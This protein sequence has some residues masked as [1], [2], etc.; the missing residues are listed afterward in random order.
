MSSTMPAGKSSVSFMG[1]NEDEH[2]PNTSAAL[3]DALLIEGGSVDPNH[4]QPAYD[5]RQSNK[6]MGSLSLA[7]EIDHNSNHRRRREPPHLSNGLHSPEGNETLEESGSISE[8]A[9]NRLQHLAEAQ[10][11]PLTPNLTASTD[12]SSPNSNTS[13]AVSPAGRLRQELEEVRQRQES[14]RILVEGSPRTPQRADFPPSL[15]MSIVAP[16]TE[17]EVEHCVVLLHQSTGNE[18]S[19]GDL[20]KSLRRS[21]PESAFVLIRG[22]QAVR[23]G[24]SGYHWADTAWEARFIQTSTVILD[25]I[26]KDVLM[27]KCHFQPQNI[28]L[29]GYREG[30]MAALAA[31]A[32]WQGFELGG[33]ISIGGP[34]PDYVQLEPGVRAK[35][36]A[37]IIGGALGEMNAAA[38]QL[39]QKSFIYTHTDIRKGEHDLIPETKEQLKPLLDFFAHRLR[40]EEWNKQAVISFGTIEFLWYQDQHA[41][42]VTDGGGVRGLGSLLILQ[43]LMNKIGDLEKSLGGPEAESSFAPRAYRPMSNQSSHTDADVNTQP[44]PSGNDIPVEPEDIIPTPTHEVPNSSLFLPCHYFDY[45]AGTSTGG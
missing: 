41:D 14:A 3:S 18:E 43:D 6:S 2:Q 32:S 39:I 35:T 19:L 45:A 42:G 12:P 17:A 27:S 24:N 16:D 37:L 25:Q 28:V 5:K 15:S 36:P 21:L 44:S 4:T 26:I 8:S 38:L 1:D 30:G 7:P 9:S 29:L 34:M 20:A 23:G 10:H 22:L 11:R 31:A 33:V 40:R 13:R